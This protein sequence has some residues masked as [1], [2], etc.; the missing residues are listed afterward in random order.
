MRIVRLVCV[1]G[2]LALA[3]VLG[4]SAAMA[5]DR[6]EPATRFDF[7]DELV[8]GDLMRPDGEI[9]QGRSRHG[10][11][12]LIRVRESFVAELYKSVEH[13]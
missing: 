9:L 13:L 11:S 5:Q 6:D 4:A 10:R 12:T 7:E 3:S 8:L 2:S 1:L